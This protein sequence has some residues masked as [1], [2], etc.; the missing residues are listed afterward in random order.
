MGQIDVQAGRSGSKM[1]QI[2]FANKYATLP[3]LAN[4]TDRKNGH[5]NGQ[6]IQG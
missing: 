5:K 4:M 6:K 3:N 1:G 2:N